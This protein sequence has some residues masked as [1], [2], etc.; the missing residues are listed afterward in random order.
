[1]WWPA[2]LSS[3]RSTYGSALYVTITAATSGMRH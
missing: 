1:V 3:D 2:T